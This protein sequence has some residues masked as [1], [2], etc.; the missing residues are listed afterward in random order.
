MGEF[1]ITI[2]HLFPDLLNLYGDKGNI[3]ALRKRLVWR[4]IDAEVKECTCDNPYINFDET[5]IFFLG[6]GTDREEKIVL[7]KLLEHKKE[8]HSFAESGGTILAVCGGFELLG[9]ELKYT[10]ETTEGLGILD[11]YTDLSN[12]KKRLIG[13]VIIECEGLSEKVVGFENHGGRIDIKNHTPL[14][15]VLKGFG[16][17]IESK[18]EGVVYKNVTATYL[19]GPLLPKNPELCDRILSQALKH[20]YKTFK[21]L[22]PLDDDFETAAKTH[23]VKKYLQKSK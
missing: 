9:K 7:E 1:K 12:S 18:F 23:I 2:V 22:S 19:H 20:K 21:N 11:I 5:D 16:N 4:G 15:H 14:G 10:D 6:G 17:N 3:E 13:D 8:F